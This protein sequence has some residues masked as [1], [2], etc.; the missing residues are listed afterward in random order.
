MV[1]SG[2]SAAGS[3]VMDVVDAAG[4]DVTLPSALVTSP[5]TTSIRTRLRS[6]SIMLRNVYGVV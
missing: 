4:A 3:N 6:L 2:T 5:P 1:E